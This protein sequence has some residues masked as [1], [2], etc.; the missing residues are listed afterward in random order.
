[1]DR[2]WMYNRV[3][4]DRKVQTQI[5]EISEDRAHEVDGAMGLQLS[6]E[7]IGS[8]SGGQVYDTTNLSTTFQHGSISHT[9]KSQTPSTPP[10]SGWSLEA[11]RWDSRVAKATHNTLVVARE[12]KE[13]AHNALVV[14]RE[15]V[16]VAREDNE[17]IQKLQNDFDCF[18]K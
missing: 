13:T 17:R 6:Q 2:T 11:D 9:Q 14:A 1:M 4:D 18:R 8:R 7:C 10:V 15:A 12:A 5:G 16:V 3:N